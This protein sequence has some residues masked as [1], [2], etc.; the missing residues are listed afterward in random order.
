MQR[1]V[2]R[3]YD[4]RGIWER[5]IDK[6]FCFL[7]GRAFGIYLKEN[8]KKP[9]GIISIGYDARLSS[10][11]ILKSLSDGL[12]CENIDIINIGLVPTPVQY[13]SLFNL[14]IDGGIMITASHNPKEY[15][16]FKLSL[17]KETL[18][19]AEIQRIA[20]I[21]EKLGSA[22]DIRAGRVK[23]ADV[24]SEYKKFMLDQF[25]YLKDYNSKPKIAL[26]GG[27]GT[28]G[29]VGYDIFKELGYEVEGL[30]IEPDGN[31][32]NHHPDPTVEKNLTDLR[33]V[34]K[35]KNI[36]VGIGYDGDGDRIGVV[37]KDGSILWGDQLLLLFAQHIAKKRTDVKVVADVKCSDVIFQKMKECGAKPIMY[38]T[39]HSLIKSKMKQEGA[40][41]AG[42][43]SGHIF[44]GDRYFGYDDAIYVSL[45][46]V[47]ILTTEGI[48][49]VQWK[50]SLPKVYNTPEIR[51]DC[52][53][54]KKTQ[55]ITKIKSY[56]NRNKD[57]IGILEINTIDG[58]RFK[59]DYG[60]GLVRASN[61]QPALVMRFEASSEEK[62]KELKDK[63]I[64]TVKG[65]INE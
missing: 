15:N 36:D 64:N 14:D 53:D 59:T 17:K 27:N 31:F 11:D 38:K 50:E 10:K 37:L 29:F 40:I 7:L 35:E 52:P 21:M 49:L 44:I 55:V 61:T 39:G 24:L 8:L 65:F 22:C 47:E 13:F 63:I 62:L 28:A 9:S 57:K 48:D 4:I 43:M 12:S 1:D 32:P 34:I 19:G 5:D 6:E 2:F 30:F 41:L 46:L 42:E 60:W 26:D 25:G 51:I 33:R 54:E 56:L 18:F 16:G 3:E 23:Q 20:D 45:R 58:V